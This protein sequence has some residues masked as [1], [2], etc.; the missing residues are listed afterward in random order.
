MIKTQGTFIA[1]YR[2]GRNMTYHEAVHW[3][4]G[5]KREVSLCYSRD[6]HTLCRNSDFDLDT[7]LQ[8]DARNL[9]HNFTGRVQVDEALV[10]LEFVTIPGLRTFTT[11]SFTGGDFEN[12]GR[13]TNGPLDTELLVLCTVDQVSR[14]LL[15]VLDVAAGEGDP[16]FVDFGSWNG[17]TCGIVFFFSFG[18]VTHFECVNESEGD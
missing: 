2:C 1:F 14:E 11:R 5:I 18:D 13:K 4:G 8:T 17:C 12:L 9:L 16:D 7:R 10:N 6:V 15:Q 3:N